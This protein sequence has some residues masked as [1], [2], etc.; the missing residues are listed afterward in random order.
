MWERGKRHST[1][2]LNGHGTEVELRAQGSRPR[3]Q[4]NIRGQRQPFRGQTL[5]KARTQAQVFS[6]KIIIIRS[7]NFFVQVFSINKIKKS[8]KK[9]VFPQKTI[10]KILRIPKI[11]L[12]SS[13]RQGN[14][15]GL[16]ASRPKTSNVSSRLHLCKRNVL[17]E[18]K[19]S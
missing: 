8:G 1:F 14:F 3:T 17:V 11:L 5:S 10:Y 7:S 12:F 19:N 4:K 6:K 2:G 18:L 9:Q 16:E 15:Q 13:R